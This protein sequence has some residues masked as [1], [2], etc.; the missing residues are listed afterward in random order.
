MFIKSC[1]LLKDSQVRMYEYKFEIV[2]KLS[3]NQIHSKAT[4]RISIRSFIRWRSRRI[5]R[6]AIESCQ[7]IE[8]QTNWKW[9]YSLWT[10]SCQ[11]LCLPICF[12]SFRWE[13][14]R[15]FL[16]EIRYFLGNFSFPSLSLRS[17]R[18]L[19]W[20]EVAWMSSHTTYT[21]KLIKTRY[22]KKDILYIPLTI[23][24]TV[25]QYFVFLVEILEVNEAI[26]CTSSVL[27]KYPISQC[28]SLQF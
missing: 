7:S 14:L 11:S 26:C 12:H 27:S 24:C 2:Q 20:K 15:I 5:R 21:Y 18:S 1:W 6:K 13:G 28:I 23:L 10:L 3:R 16:W 8:L 4:R 19:L 25:K 17:S 22:T 9:N